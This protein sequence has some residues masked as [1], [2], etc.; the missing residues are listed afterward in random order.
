MLAK[1]SRGWGL[2]NTALEY[3]SYVMAMPQLRNTRW[4]NCK[5]RKY[6]R[7]LLSLPFSFTVCTSVPGN[8]WLWGKHLS[9]C[10]RSSDCFQCLQ[11][12]LDMSLTIRSVLPECKWFTTNYG[13]SSSSKQRMKAQLTL[14]VGNS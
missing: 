3:T 5:L 7:Y 12:F 11:Q 14:V 10:H 13:S 1:S 6:G 2:E 8:R 9:W 4:R